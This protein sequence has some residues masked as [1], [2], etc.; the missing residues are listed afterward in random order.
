MQYRFATSADTATLAAMSGRARNSCRSRRRRSQDSKA[1]AIRD[2]AHAI[3]VG[4]RAS[5]WPA[6]PWFAAS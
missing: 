2:H 1:P 5:L 3:S 6:F 4:F